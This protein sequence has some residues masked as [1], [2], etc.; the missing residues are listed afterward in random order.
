MDGQHPQATMAVS[1]ATDVGLVRKNN[2]DCVA[3]GHVI[4]NGVGYSIWIVADGVGGGPKGEKASRMAVK[5]AMGHLA[6]SKWTDPVEALAEAFALANTRVYAIT[7]SGA[8]ATTMVAALASDADP[9]VWIAN[10]GDSRAYVVA[11]GGTR[12]VTEDHS[13]AAARVAAGRITAAEARNAPDRNILTR[14]VGA[15]SVVVVDVFG[16]MA[17]ADGE[18][19]VLC[20]DGVH[21]LIG[22]FEIGRIASALPIA[23]TARALVDA[24]L[25]AGGRDNATAL[26]GGHADPR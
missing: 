5:T 14:G 6:E 8:A 3:A 22:D 17:L 11:G 18:R 10:V 13:L 19:L 7:G 26:V 1:T 21:D 2:E 16:P 4:R 23:D 12:M 24:A 9:S 25:E 15:E 20:T